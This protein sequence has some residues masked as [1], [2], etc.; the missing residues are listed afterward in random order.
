M[1]LL[2]SVA[3]WA[4][5]NDVTTIFTVLFILLLVVMV[6]VLAFCVYWLY[7]TNA[8]SR[9]VLLTMPIRGDDYFLDGRRK[10]FKIVN[11]NMNGGKGIPLPYVGD[12]LIWQYAPPQMPPLNQRVQFTVCFWTKIDNLTTQ[13]DTLNYASVLTMGRKKEFEISYNFYANMLKI[14]VATKDPKRRD[15]VYTTPNFFTIQ[16]WQLVT[17]SVDNRRID[18]FCDRTLVSSHV[19]TNVP[20]FRRG[21]GAGDGLDSNNVWRLFAGDVPY[22][23]V[24]SCIRY[25]EYPFDNHD[26]NRFYLATVAGGEAPT[27]PYFTWWTWYKS[28]ALSDVFF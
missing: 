3:N 25:F 4:E 11:R 14:R 16:K 10:K 20:I 6:L 9:P 26:V 21:G 22:T 15:L 18:V 2:A 13:Y 17:I 5:R 28:N 1:L 24:V 19:M 27:Y 7:Q 12:E 23:G 8:R